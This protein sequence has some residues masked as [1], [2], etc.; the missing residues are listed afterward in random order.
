MASFPWC[1]QKWK[2][3]GWEDWY[4]HAT[5]WSSHQV[6][7]TTPIWFPVM[8]A[9]G[10]VMSSCLSRTSLSFTDNAFFFHIVVFFCI[11][12]TFQ[13]SF[14]GSC[15]WGSP[16]PSPN[17][18]VSEWTLHWNFHSQC[19]P[20]HAMEANI[21]GTRECHAQLPLTIGY[22]HFP[23]VIFL[24]SIHPWMWLGLYSWIH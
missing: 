2:C 1:S 5:C 10:M 21:T 6:P 7:A 12:H 3:C 23:D 24:S 15:A 17:A 16:N 14:T 19:P 8:L 18:T 20:S 22:W 13:H 11:C 4:K 9:H